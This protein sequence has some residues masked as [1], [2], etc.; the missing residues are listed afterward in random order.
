M[1]PVHVGPSGSR[2]PGIGTLLVAFAFLL[3]GCGGPTASPV[4]ASPSAITP[5]PSTAAVTAS[6]APTGSPSAASDKITVPNSW[7]KTRDVASSLFVSKG[8]AVGTLKSKPLGVDPIPDTWIVFSQNPQPGTLAAP[9]TPVNL[10]M[11][12][13]SSSS[14]TSACS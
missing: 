10:E 8:L 3:G 4:T 14:A 13:P 9:G 1:T 5:A 6:A 11:V 12:D 7:C 2:R